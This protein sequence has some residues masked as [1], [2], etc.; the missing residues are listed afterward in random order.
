[1]LKAICLSKAGDLAK[2]RIVF[3][4]GEA[5]MKDR[6]LAYLP[7]AEGF[8]DHEERSYLIHRREAQALLTAAAPTQ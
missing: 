8:I 5:L 7:E 3:D 6:L 4:E 2:A 1:L